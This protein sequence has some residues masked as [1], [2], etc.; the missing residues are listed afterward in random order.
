MRPWKSPSFI[1]RWITEDKL[2]TG[3]LRRTD[4]I[5]GY[6][7]FQFSILI[8]QQYV[9]WQKLYWFSSKICNFSKIP[10]KSNDF[11]RKLNVLIQ[12]LDKITNVKLFVCFCES[13]KMLFI[14]FCLFA[15]FQPKV[16]ILQFLKW[17]ELRQPIVT[18][19]TDFS[20]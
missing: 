19:Y 15:R 1:V 18:C 16:L 7:F 9:I 11:V 6:W 4:K 17:N 10:T 12:Y 2:F 3:V 5:S 13:L 8:L 20:T 14:P